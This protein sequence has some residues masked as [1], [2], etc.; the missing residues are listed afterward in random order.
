MASK[1]LAL[2]K[3]KIFIA[4]TGESLEVA[5]AVQINL[6]SDFE[7]KVWDQNAF[8]L[9]TFT[10]E[11]LKA[12]LDAS[13]FGIFVATPDD[14]ARVRGKKFGVPR[15]NVIFELGLFVGRLGI[16][17]SFIIVPSPRS[18]V[19]L[20]SDLE[21]ITVGDYIAN[22]QDNDL[23]PALAPVCNRIR[24]SIKEYTKTALESLVA[25]NRIS[26]FTQF[27]DAFAPLLEKSDSVRLFFIHSRRWRENNNEAIRNF[28]SR[29]RSRLTV[30]LPNPGNNLLVSSISSHF[31]DGPH[32]PG[33]VCDAYRYFVTL[34]KEFKNKIRFRQFN[35]Y[36]TYS[37]YEFDDRIIVALYPLSNMRK[38]VPTLEIRRA[39]SLF[40]FFQ[41]DI[42]S[43]DDS[44]PLI[45]LA[46]AQLISSKTVPKKRRSRF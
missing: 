33:F 3:P 10:Y 7:T 32:I 13:H 34:A 8:K 46:H 45:S 5:R 4:S 21:S 26:T 31:D 2:F 19:K 22:R 11:A 6:D 29:T 28:L 25:S 38:D 41:K 35:L 23:I 15:D 9:S 20:P 39:S 40:E 43:L 1:P 30:Y 42:K 17:R 37:F 44:A 36:P 27:N 16:K 24:Q 14:S 18:S 12:E